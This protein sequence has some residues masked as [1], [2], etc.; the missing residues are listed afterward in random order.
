[1]TARATWDRL[2]GRA[3]RRRP[4]RA[5][6]PTPYLAEVNNGGALVTE[7]I[8]AVHRNARVITCNA[9]RGKYR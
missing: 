8:K 6:G 9:A 7:N 5:G 2:A 4:M 3:A 1:M